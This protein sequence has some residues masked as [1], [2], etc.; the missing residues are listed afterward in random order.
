MAWGTPLTG[1]LTWN[2]CGHEKDKIV[3]HVV[4]K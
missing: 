2:I 1:P 4:T 3:E